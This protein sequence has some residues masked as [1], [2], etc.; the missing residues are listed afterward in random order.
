MQ[1]LYEHNVN[2]KKFF[3]KIKL[4]KKIIFLNN[5]IIANEDYARNDIKNLLSHENE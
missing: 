1:Q 3:L 5:V 4:I 2:S